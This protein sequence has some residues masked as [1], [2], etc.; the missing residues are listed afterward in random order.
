MKFSEWL[1]SK[2]YKSMMRRLRSLPP[3]LVEAELVHGQT[4]KITFKTGNPVVDISLAG[5]FV[6]FLHDY[7]KSHNMI[8]TGYLS[9]SIT[10]RGNVV[11]I[12]AY[13]YYY[14]MT[15]LSP[16]REGKFPPIEKIEIWLS[17]K[18]GYSGDELER[19][20]YRVSRSIAQHGMKPRLRLWDLMHEFIEFYVGQGRITLNF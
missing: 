15:G 6:K 3:V 13:Y 1:E 12:G 7:L 9:R 14:L 16:Y 5:G 10:R 8:A 2:Q 11:Y 17:Y 19:R 4:G 20:A 18:F